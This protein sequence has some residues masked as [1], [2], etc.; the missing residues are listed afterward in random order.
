MARCGRGGCRALACEGDGRPPPK[1]TLCSSTWQPLSYNVLERGRSHT[2]PP[3]SGR[4]R[5]LW[6]GDATSTV[7]PRAPSEIH[8]D[9]HIGLSCSTG[10]VDNAARLRSKR[11]RSRYRGAKER[12]GGIL[13]AV[14]VP[15]H[16]SQGPSG[17]TRAESRALRVSAFREGSVPSLP[18]RDA[19]GQRS[20]ANPA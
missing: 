8:P 14:P 11:H 16:G 6:G 3:G 18:R 12:S 7:R 20:R 9:C 1:K 4:R 17:A 10:M 5:H 19:S 13:V 15:N 2:D